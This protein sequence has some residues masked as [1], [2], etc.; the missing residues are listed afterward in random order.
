MDNQSATLQRFAAPTKPA[1]VLQSDVND[2]PASSLPVD[3]DMADMSLGERLMAL[4]NGDARP[5]GESQK[6]KAAKVF[7]GPANAAS[8]TRLM[9]QALHTADPALL[10]VCLSYRDPVLIRNTIRKMP[11]QL[12]LPLLKACVEQLGQ[13]KA[14][15]KRGGGRGSGQNEQQGRGTVE[16]VKGVLVERGALLMTVILM[17]CRADE[18]DQ[19]FR[20]LLCLCI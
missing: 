7:E 12:A 19:E 6:H 2:G 5:N 4:P 11:A 1:Q 17:T 8:L 20:C 16:W 18:A 10:A 9:V 3:V 15:N 13:G 14:A